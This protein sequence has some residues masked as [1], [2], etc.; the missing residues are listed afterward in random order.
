MLLTVHEST[1]S[2]SISTLFVYVYTSAVG[3]V[4][5]ICGCAQLC[6]YQKILISFSFC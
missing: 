2:Y 4:S 5:D 1:F 3:P 6:Q